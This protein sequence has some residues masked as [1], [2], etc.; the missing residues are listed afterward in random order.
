[1]A[2]ETKKEPTTASTLNEWRKAEQVVAVARR[3][4]LAAE[5][6]V[7][8]AQEAADAATATAAAA[9]AALESATL[10][11]KSAEKTA[12]AARVIIEMAGANLTD[13]QAES[14]RR[15]SKRQAPMAGIEMLSIA[16][17]RVKRAPDPDRPRG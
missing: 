9:K 4:R 7:A 15:T 11:E 8:A 5:A 14:D 1:M 17:R 12:A 13:A 3:G 2:D 6:A 16:R 10:A